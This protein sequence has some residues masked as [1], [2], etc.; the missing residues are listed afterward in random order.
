M[1]DFN[2]IN[3]Q[4]IVMWICFGKQ[5]QL[6]NCIFL[7]LIL[8]LLWVPGVYTNMEVGWQRRERE[9]KQGLESSVDTCGLQ[10]NG[11]TDC[12]GSKGLEPIDPAP[13]VLMKKPRS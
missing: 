1:K 4:M 3:N 2:T 13:S 8:R 9:M 5:I 6:V 7:R 11:V 12:Q 10:T